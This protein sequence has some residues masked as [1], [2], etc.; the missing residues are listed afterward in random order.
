MTAW[1]PLDSVLAP[2]HVG[3]AAATPPPI[4]L[5]DRKQ[6]SNPVVVWTLVAAAVAFVGGVVFFGY[7]AMQVAPIVRQNV[8]Q[9]NNSDG[10]EAAS[11][12]LSWTT[13]T[14][15]EA[16]VRNRA[17]EFRVRQYLD[18]YRKD[19]RRE[20]SWDTEAQQF[21]ES[22][23]VSNYGG[24]ENTNALS[25]RE[26]GDRLAANPACND[27]LVLTAAAAESIEVHEK[28]RRLERALAAYPNSRYKAYPRMFATVSLASELGNQKERLSALDNSA[29]Q[30]FKDALGD[31]SFG[32]QDEPELAQV[33]IAGWGRNFF[34]RNGAALCPMVRGATGFAWLALVLEGEFQVNEAW[35]AR[36][37]GYADTVTQDGWQGFADHLAKARSAFAKAWELRPEHALAPTRMITVAMGQGGAA[38][39]RTWF[40]RAIAAQIDE[41]DAW[42]SMRWGLRPR[43]HGSHEAMLGLGSTA[44]DTK[45]FDTDVPRK[46]FDVVADI[47]AELELSP[48]EHIYGRQDVWPQFQRLYEGYIAA[49]S[50]QATRD[51]WRSSYATVAYFAAKYDVARDQFEALNWKP[52]P[53][54]LT[55]W[56]VDLSLMPLKVAALTGASATKAAR[57]EASYDR[58][59]AAEA[60]RL[61]GELSSAA[62]ADERTREFCRHRLAALREEALLA[63]GEWIDLVPKDEKD[64]NWVTPRGK[65]RQIGNGAVELEADAEGH[66][67]FSRVRVGAEFEVSGEFEVVRSSTRDFQAGLV[68][69]LPEPTSSGW[70]GFRM[71][72]NSVD[73]E[74]VSF[75]QGWG[76]QDVHQAVTLNS[77]RN[78]FRFKFH[79]CKAAAWLNGVLVLQQAAPSKK[80]RINQES[81]LGLG[82]FNDMNDTVI[83]YRNLKVRR[84]GLRERDDG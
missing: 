36:G 47:E 64:L 18:G 84:L 68:M 15:T 65:V 69:G 54:N 83:R 12:P 71:K 32:P 23:I 17:K 3:A 76:R 45:R 59:Q 60:A 51:G 53:R 20:Q 58:H 28:I 16:D 39:M 6:K 67:L 7:L 38:E 41:P 48:G 79:N 61:Y 42:S 10:R 72:R 81:L 25:A 75:A 13:N 49:P 1:V 56:G 82:A 43:W 29:V 62:E 30:L 40:E 80:M 55:G 52:W 22:W 19:G 44:I 9:A 66:L 14:L 77:D 34:K 5:R 35:K 37:G 21:I 4:P 24:P 8:R 74:M 2:S 70:Y 31:G 63:K 33:L 73:G 11:K 57:A 26:L 78:S 27:P 46:F 50:Q